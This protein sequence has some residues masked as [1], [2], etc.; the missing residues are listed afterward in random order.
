MFMEKLR[1]RL[2]IYF[3][4]NLSRLVS[5]AKPRALG[6]GT[7]LD[8]YTVQPMV[9][10]GTRPLR[11]PGRPC[12]ASAARQIGA[13]ISTRAAPGA[14]GL[15]SAGNTEHYIVWASSLKHFLVADWCQ[16]PPSLPN[17]PL[18]V[19]CVQCSPCMTHCFWP[20]LW[21]LP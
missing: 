21:C 20:T 13:Q 1:D 19:M 18:S 6:H 16:S 7:C 11:W 14:T 12:D 2:G 15:P 4:L 17:H 3:H 5:R 8:R 9:T 10:L